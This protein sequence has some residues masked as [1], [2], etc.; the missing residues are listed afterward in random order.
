MESADTTDPRIERTVRV[1]KK[2]VA[3][4]AHR[5]KQQQALRDAQVEISKPQL[6]L[7]TEGEKMIHRLLE[8]EKAVTQVLSANRT[9]RKISSQ[10]DLTL[11][12]HVKTSVT[13]EEVEKLYEDNV[14]VASTQKI[15]EEM[16]QIS[17]Q[18]DSTITLLQDSEMND[19]SLDYGV[20]E[21]DQ[22]QDQAI[23]DVEAETCSN[24]AIVDPTCI[25]S[26]HQDLEYKKPALWIFFGHLTAETPEA[27]VRDELHEPQ[28][29]E[30]WRQ[31]DRGCT[32]M[33]SLSRNT[34]SFH[35]GIPPLQ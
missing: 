22:D 3:A 30:V 16:Q 12:P 34:P 2:I 1:I 6:R 35:M 9:R 26:L 7:V 25:H 23:K 31:Q 19:I 18:S 11:T 29:C 10:T 13:E 21:P 20:N 5:W 33:H 14:H 32:Y 15:E 17:E 28:S 4:F 24:Q 8:P 27:V